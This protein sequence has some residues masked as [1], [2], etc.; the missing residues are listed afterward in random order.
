[1]DELLEL[2]FPGGALVGI[3]IAIGAAF[4][5]QLRPVAKQALKAG[6]AVGDQVRVA[7]AEAAERAQDLMAEA[8]SEHD[9]EL[10]Q[11]NG[12]AEPAG[13]RAGSPTA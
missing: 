5:K 11:R 3:G 12:Q 2:I 7:A 6:M 1:M 8:R 4:S 9:A 10:Q 13:V